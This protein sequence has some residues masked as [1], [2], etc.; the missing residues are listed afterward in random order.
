CVPRGLSAD[1]TT[2]VQAPVIGIGAAPECDG[3]VL[4]MHDMLGLN[5]R[6]A[7]FVKDFMADAGGDISAAFR[8]YDQ[9]V[10][11]GTFPTDE[12]CF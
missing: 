9:A 1:I 2:A 5:P 10:R 3:Q 6:P 12:H 4:V 8:A 11:E 7:R